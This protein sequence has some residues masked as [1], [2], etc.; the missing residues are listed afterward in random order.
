[1]GTSSGVYTD[2]ET[3][4]QSPLMGWTAASISKGITGLTAGR[5]YYFRAVASNSSYY[6]RGNELTFATGALG[7]D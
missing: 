3:A 7:P 2:S 6:V 5:I 1:M 4:D